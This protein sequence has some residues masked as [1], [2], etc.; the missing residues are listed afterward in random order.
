MPDLPTVAEAGVSGFEATTWHG[1]VAAAGTPEPLITRLNAEI[2]R[3]LRLADVRERL[4]GQGAEISGGTPQEFA[5]YI[6][7]EIPKWAKV[8]K[9]SGA[10]AD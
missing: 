8:V 4:T 7:R 1:V 2:N 3:V 9:D 10:R 6:Q 5:A